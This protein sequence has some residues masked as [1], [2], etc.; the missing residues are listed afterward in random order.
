MAGGVFDLCRSPDIDAGFD[1]ALAQAV[2]DGTRR[3]ITARF[4]NDLE[5]TFPKAQAVFVLPRGTYRVTGGTAE[6]TFESDDRAFTIMV[7][8]FDLPAK[9]RGS[10]T[11]EP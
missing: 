3:Q 4:E 7:V 6:H 10:V 1:L 2:D 9:S 8:R 5:E 11:V